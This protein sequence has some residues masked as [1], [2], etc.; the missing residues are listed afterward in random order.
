MQFSN[1]ALSRRLE[2][3]EGFACAESADARQRLFP[4]SGAEWMECAGTY[5]VFNGVNSPIT[6][7]FGLGLLEELTS[8]ASFSTGERM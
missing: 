3:A 6:Q 2:R 5:A 8:R 4:D 7:T 1:L